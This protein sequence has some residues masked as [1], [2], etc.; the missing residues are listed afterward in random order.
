M[1]T[2]ALI[3]MGKDGTFGIF[4]PD[5]EST[6]CGEGK[7][8]LEAKLDFW[9]GYKEM[10][11]SYEDTDEEIPDELKDLEFTYRY[12]MASLFN[13]CN[14]L[15]VSKLAEA[16]D[17]NPSLLRQYKV[18]NTYISEKQAK[19]IEAGLHQLGEQLLSVSL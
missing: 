16:I 2:R 5:L 7:T 14:F 4:T 8:V 6:I 19:K 13:Y 12:D 17:V 15:N 18:G 1:K 11:L 10:L 3:E 9:E